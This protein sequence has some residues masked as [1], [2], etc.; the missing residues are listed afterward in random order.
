MGREPKE[1]K[2]V[3][4]RCSSGTQSASFFPNISCSSSLGL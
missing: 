1:H 2:A 4:E 3:K